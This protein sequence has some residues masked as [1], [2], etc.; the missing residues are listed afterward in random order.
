MQAPPEYSITPKAPPGSP[1]GSLCGCLQVCKEAKAQTRLSSQL[2]GASPPIGPLGQ[3]PLEVA[4]T[5]Q[6]PSK[7]RGGPKPLLLLGPWMPM[8]Q[9]PGQLVSP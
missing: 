4:C 5:R 3:G 1:Q 2:L 6:D 8:A 7:G 9:M